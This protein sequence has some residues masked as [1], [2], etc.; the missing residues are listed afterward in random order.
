MICDRLLTRATSGVVLMLVLTACQTTAE[1]T[2]GAA[3]GQPSEPMI[4]EQATFLEAARG[5]EKSRNYDQAAALYGRLFERRPTDPDILAAFIRNMRYSGRAQEVVN[6][7]A[8]KTPHMLDDANVKFEYAKALLASGREGEALT[9]LQESHAQTPDKWQVHSAI[10]ITLDTMERY[11]EAQAAYARALRLSPRNAV[12]MNNQAMSLASA[13]R[14]AEA[15]SVLE[16]A[17]G[18]NRTN[19]NIR[20]NL[21][22]LY[23]ID[24]NME[25]ARALAAMDLGIEELETNLSFYRRFESVGGGAR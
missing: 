19:V 6:Y 17:A 2:A 11:G 1:S 14:L 9:A 8:T 25:R 4:A 22:L 16:R 5:A 20:Q 15:I 21:A 10:G 7:T 18:L 23:A 12:V 3:V 24:G 13:G